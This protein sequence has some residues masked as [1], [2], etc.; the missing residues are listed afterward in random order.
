M[1]AAL[2]HAAGIQP[3]GCGTARRNASQGRQNAVPGTERRITMFEVIGET[4]V[5][6]LPRGGGFSSGIETEGAVKKAEHI[7]QVRP[8]EHA[9]ESERPKPQGKG[10]EHLQT[11]NRLEDGKIVVEKYDED[12]KLVKKTPP[13]YLPLGG[14]FA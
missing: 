2:A 6:Q 1:C 5:Q 14:E 3:A 4:A 10:E 7:R 12:G 9:T 8:V 11:R 13:G